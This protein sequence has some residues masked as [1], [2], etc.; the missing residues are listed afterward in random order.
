MTFPDRFHH[1]DGTHRGT[2]QSTDGHELELFE[3][4]F[5]QHVA[6]GHV[7]CPEC[8]GTDIEIEVPATF[9]LNGGFVR[10]ESPYKLR[11]YCARKR[12]DDPTLY[13][14]CWSSYT[15]EHDTR[16]LDA[17]F[18]RFGAAVD[19]AQDKLLGP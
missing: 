2:A 10:F 8:G 7:H 4:G 9:K 16:H 3:A 13:D 6:D 15:D 17:P 1:E 5:R 12:K 18:G 19:A 11:I 14:P